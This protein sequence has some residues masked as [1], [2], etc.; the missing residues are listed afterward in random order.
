MDPLAEID[1]DAEAIWLDGAWHTREALAHRIKQMVESGEYKVARLSEALERLE[2]GL[3]QTRILSSRVPEDLAAA[4]AAAGSQ[5]GR[6][7]GHLVREAVAYYLAAAAAHA[8]SRS[9][10]A[11]AQDG[12]PREDGSAAVLGKKTGA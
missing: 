8:A 1:L 12:A 5:L 9:R 6:P 7:V 2:A 11:S 10:P 3:A 4:L